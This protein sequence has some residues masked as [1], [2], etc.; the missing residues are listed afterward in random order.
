MILIRSCHTMMGDI[1]NRILAFTRPTFTLQL[2][3]KEYL[4]HEQFHHIF[5]GHLTKLIR[6]TR[7]MNESLQ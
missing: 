3:I 7:I 4:V 1:H 2:I 6:C 5:Q